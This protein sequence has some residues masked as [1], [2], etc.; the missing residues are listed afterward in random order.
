MILGIAKETVKVFG[1][2][3]Y[4][5]GKAVFKAGAIVLGVKGAVSA[6]MYFLNKSNEFGKQGRSTVDWL[7]K[8][9]LRLDGY[10][11]SS[12]TDR[13]YLN[14]FKNNTGSVKRSTLVEPD[15]RS[16]SD[17]KQEPSIV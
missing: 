1:R 16:A 8:I 14:D 11:V 17:N 5:C 2:S 10:D 7:D 13:K 4:T 6:G 12:L 15:I 9:K 3:M